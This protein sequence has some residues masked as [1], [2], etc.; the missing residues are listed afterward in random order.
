MLSNEEGPD[1]SEGVDIEAE[2]LNKLPT[3]DGA[4][5]KGSSP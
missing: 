5:D 2:A 1:D 3:G 4:Y